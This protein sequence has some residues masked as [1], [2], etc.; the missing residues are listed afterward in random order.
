MWTERGFP[1]A[2]HIALHVIFALAIVARFYVAYLDGWPLAIMVPGI[3][4]GMGWLAFGIRHA[5]GNLHGL[6]DKL[7]GSQPYRST[8][9]KQ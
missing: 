9:E 2:L 8:N 1:M 5:T 6:L 4:L 3:L 7:F